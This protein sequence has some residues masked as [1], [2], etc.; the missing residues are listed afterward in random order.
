MNCNDSSNESQKMNTCFPQNDPST[1]FSIVVFFN[2]IICLC[3]LLGNGIVLWFLSFYIKKNHFTIYILNLTVADF[4]FLLG[5][6]VW[7]LAKI[8]YVYSSKLTKCSMFYICHGTLLFNIFLY[9]TGLG[10]LTVIS[11]ERCLSMLYPLWYRYHHLK[12]KS[13]FICAFIWF[14]SVFM[15]FLEFYFEIYMGYTY[16]TWRYGISIFCCV[17]NFLVFTPL[18]VISSLILFLKSWKRSQHHHPARLHIIIL[19]TILVFLVFGLPQ[20]VWFALHFGFQVTF[21]ESV[22]FIIQLFS[23]I[24]SS[25]NP[26]IYFFVGNLWKNKK[27]KSLKVS[28]LKVFKEDFQGRGTRTTLHDINSETI[29]KRDPQ[30]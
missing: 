16:K 28:L 15:T 13:P 5:R 9:N 25:A 3:G 10:F 7:Y 30:K 26:A 24:N 11:L 4:S 29:R 18:M 1:E 19:V 12:K 17:L 6:V 23:C 14:L 20:K 8:L 22:S 2:L 27:R 21:L